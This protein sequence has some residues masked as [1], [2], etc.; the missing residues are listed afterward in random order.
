MGNAISTLTGLRIIM[1]L[2]GAVLS[3]CAFLVSHQ[4]FYPLLPGD[5]SAAQNILASVG[6]SFLFAVVIDTI[7]QIQRQLR[8]RQFRHFFGNSALLGDIK[9]VYPDFILNP[10]I[11]R[12]PSEIQN[13]S[14]YKK[15]NPAFEMNRF[16][17]VPHAVAA[18]DLQGAVI[19]ASMLG[20]YSIRSAELIPDSTA[21]YSVNES[22]ISFGFSS[23]DM[24]K[25]YL[26]MD[27]EPLFNICDDENGKL[28]LNLL[29]SDETKLYS[30]DDK[31]QHAIILKFRPQPRREPNRIWII[32]AGLGAAGTPAAAWCLAKSWKDY[33]RRFGQNDFIVILRVSNSL[34][35]YQSAVEAAS[36]VRG[37]KK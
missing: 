7:W 17:D 36:F 14:T 22:F 4:K 1:F 11:L 32:C 29:G 9:L 13:L 37:Q 26:E 8:K 24:T 16:I 23:N 19:V 31:S 27:P 28:C 2:I 33:E 5:L 25:L 6:S 35:A 18:N 21:V 10:D 34:A 15:R 12:P 20:E 3:I 30:R